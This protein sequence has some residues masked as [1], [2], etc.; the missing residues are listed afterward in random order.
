MGAYSRLGAY[1]FSLPSGWALIRGWALNRINKV[2]L[3]F[4][5][6]PSCIELFKAENASIT[7]FVGFQNL[8]LT[9]SDRTV[10]HSV[11]GQLCRLICTLGVRAFSCAVSGVSHF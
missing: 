11:S 5:C 6:L 3:H 8:H 9:L 10:L 2:I 4:S 1:Y 7:N